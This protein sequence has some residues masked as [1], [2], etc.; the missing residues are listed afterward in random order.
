MVRFHPAIAGIALVALLISFHQYQIH[1]NPCYEV[2]RLHVV[3]NSDSP[4]D[5]AVKLKVR[6]SVLK[7][8]DSRFAGVDDAGEARR[9]AEA[10]LQDIEQTAEETLSAYGHNYP[11][12]A[13]VGN[14]DFPTRFYGTQV[15]PPGEYTAVRVVLGEGAGRNW[16]CVLFPPLCLNNIDEQS[17]QPIENPE[18]KLKLVEVLKDQPWIQ[19]IAGSR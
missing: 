10:S 8:M 18:L 16:W 9:I 15:F 1:K 13:M 6:D 4:Y 14:F 5:Q 19:K 12:K 17:G 11:V 3:A 2:L 7:L